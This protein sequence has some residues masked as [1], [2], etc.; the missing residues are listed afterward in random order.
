[1]ESTEGPENENKPAERW[2]IVSGSLFLVFITL[3]YEI[4][5][6]RQQ[7]KNVNIN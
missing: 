4:L 6:Y 3:L 2:W 1:M 7:Q 5:R